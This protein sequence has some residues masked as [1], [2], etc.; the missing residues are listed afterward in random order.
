MRGGSVAPVFCSRSGTMTG[1]LA[2]G[3]MPAIMTSFDMLC[4]KESG[5]YGQEVAIMET[6]YVHGG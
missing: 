5:E 6:R 2:T 4:S 3:V 1:L